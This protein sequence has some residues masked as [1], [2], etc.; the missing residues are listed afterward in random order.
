M[1]SGLSKMFNR[2]VAAASMRF[3]VTKANLWRDSYNPLRGLTIS[4]SVSLLEE[5]ERGAFA[6]LQWLYRYVEMQDATLGALVE[7]RT[8]AV[9]KMGWDVKIPEGLTGA[10]LALAE[11]QAEVLKGTY[12]G[13][14]NLKAAIEFLCM[15]SFRGF[16][17]LEVVREDGVITELAPVEQWYWVREGLNGAWLYNGESKLGTTQGEDISER[18]FVIREVAR[19]IN[20]VALIGFVRKSMSQKDWDGF[21]ETF[22]IPAVFII[23]PP[24]ISEGD[25]EKYQAVADGIVSDAKGVLPSGSDVKTVDNG[26]RGV[27]PF[28]EHIKYQDE[29]LV[30]R[31]TGGKL[32]MLAESGSGTL[33]GEAHKGSFD[34]IAE[35][36]AVEIS[37]FL[38]CSVDELVLEENFP[39]QARHAYFCIAAN[40]ETDSGAVVEDVVN[41]EKAGYRVKRDQVSEKTGYELEAG[42]AEEDEERER[43]LRNREVGILRL[44]KNMT[45]DDVPEDSEDLEEVAELAGFLRESREGLESA[46]D[47]D[48]TP[49]FLLL[50]EAGR[51]ESE[52]ERD[53][54]LAKVSPLLEELGLDRSTEAFE[55]LLSSA[56]V[57]GFAETNT[58]QSES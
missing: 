20:R 4:R 9:Q 1:I 14:G 43:S 12:N 34:E 40:E 53:A 16:S 11:R 10:D 31:G 3:H 8:S 38:Q 52:D 35:A 22:G 32:T 27:N 7:R 45:A 49:L 51:A 56:L 57:N 30:L 17:H 29:Q 39:G 23:A 19:P 21:I 41:L 2:A 42:P 5:G 44:L 58:E 46:Q 37:E 15:A 36:E 48:F 50:E 6:G 28:L 47:E 55:A 26:A 18:D 54:A 13:I 25:E 24:D 33:A